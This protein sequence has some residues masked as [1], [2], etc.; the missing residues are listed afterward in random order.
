MVLPFALPRSDAESSSTVIPVAGGALATLGIV[1]GVIVQLEDGGPFSGM[2]NLFVLGAGLN[3]LILTWSIVV[4]VSSLV[5]AWRAKAKYLLVV[6]VFF[7]IC[8]ASLILFA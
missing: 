3:F 2:A 8:M 7:A 6:P 5:P 4:V 1:I